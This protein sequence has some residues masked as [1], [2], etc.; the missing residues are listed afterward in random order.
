MYDTGL[1]PERCLGAKPDSW[2]VIRAF[3][4]ENIEEGQM[5]DKDSTWV[6][7]ED[8]QEGEGYRLYIKLIDNLQGDSLSKEGFKYCENLG[9][10][11]VYLDT[12]AAEECLQEAI[13][14]GRA[15]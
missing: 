9:M 5:Y 2:L 1:G 6:V 11:W 14:P 4:G 8:L 12:K 3:A 10:V 15:R 13:L 7:E